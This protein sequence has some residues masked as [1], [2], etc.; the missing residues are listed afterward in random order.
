[1]RRRRA[2]APAAA[3]VT[4]A[5]GGCAGTDRSGQPVAAS[6]DPPSTSVVCDIQDPGPP[7]AQTLM[8]WV[9]SGGAFGP[10][11]DWTRAWEL[12]AYRDGTVLRT[13]GSGF[14]SA[15]LRPTTVDRLDPCRVRDAVSGLQELTET[16]VDIPLPTDMSTTTISIRDGAPGPAEELKIYGLGQE[17]W[18]LD[19]AGP[20]N[21]DRER[22]QQAAENRQMVIALLAG[23]TDKPQPWH[24]DRVRLVERTGEPYG[25]APPTLTGPRGSVDEV[26]TRSATVPACGEV[27]GDHVDTLLE[28][29][30]NAPAQSRWS[31]PYRTTLVAAAPLMPGQLGCPE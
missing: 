17:S 2:L 11:Q 5:L 10:P 29:L 15:P 16:D 27:T 19:A 3:V 12:A 20:P 9:D 26:M 18:Y 7:S 24:P 4:M 6:A 28:G 8:L 13:T 21:K 14:N 22:G 1:M 23:L 31:D 30:G 25:Y